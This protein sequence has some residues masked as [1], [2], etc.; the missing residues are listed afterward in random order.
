MMEA[1]GGRAFSEK[2]EKA[3]LLQYEDKAFNYALRN[4]VLP[5]RY[6]LGEMKGGW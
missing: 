3:N 4:A 1:L 2:L 6:E 5:V